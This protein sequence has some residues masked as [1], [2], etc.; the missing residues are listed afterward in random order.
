[1]YLQKRTYS[2]YFRIQVP[3]SLRS[4]Y[5]RSEITISLN[6]LNLKDARLKSLQY[7]QQYLLEFEQKKSAGKVAQDVAPVVKKVSD[8]SAVTFSD[9]YRKYLNERKPSEKSVAEFDTVF[10]RFTAVC[11]DK[12]VRLYGKSDIVKFKD[13]LLQ[14]PKYVKQSHCSPSKWLV[15]GDLSQKKQVVK[16]WYWRNLPDFL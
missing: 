2:Y 8:L 1:M 9:V 10:K 11:D 4:V 5:G 3:S 14:C 15:F 7:I 6:T 12:D 13:F 16:R